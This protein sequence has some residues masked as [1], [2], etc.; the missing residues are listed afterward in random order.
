[1]PVVD[2]HEREDADQHRQGQ[3]PHRSS[4]QHR[5]GEHGHAPEAHAGRPQTENR[6]DQ[7]GCAE[8]QGGEH[9]GQ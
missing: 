9:G 3:Q 8:K 5:P 4:D 6:G 1:M 2:V 7:A